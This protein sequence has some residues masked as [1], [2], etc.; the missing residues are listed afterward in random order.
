ML[1]N[2]L[3]KGKNIKAFKAVEDSPP[4]IEVNSKTHASKFFLVMKLIAFL[5]TIGILQVSAH[6]YSQKVSYSG[7]N[8]PI[9][10]VLKAIEKQ[11]G[12]YLFYKY[13][14]IKDAK[15]ID[16]L[17]LKNADLKHA[18]SEI[19][20]D[21]PFEYFLKENTI[22]VNKRGTVKANES[23]FRQILIDVKGV[24]VDEK[25][26]PLPGASVKTKTGN[27]GTV[28]DNQ[29]RFSMKNLTEGTVL[30][31]SYTGFETKEIEVK[32]N[33]DLHITL[34][35]AQSDL[36]E[37]VVVGYG[38]QKKELVT[39]AIGSLKIKD[40][41]VRQVASVTRL[42]EG[43]IAGV[44]LS[45]GSGNLASAERV[46][47][48]GYSSITAGNNPLYVVDGVPINTSNLSLTDFGENYSPLAVLN[49]ADVE[50]IEVLKDAASGAIYGSR[51]SN[52]V[53]L[54]TTK[55][56]KEGKSQI[57]FDLST[58]FSEFA[59]KN[60]LKLASSD[61]YLLQ[62]NEGAENYNK[63]YGLKIGDSGY[64]TPI[65]NPFYDMPDTDWLGL[66]LQKGYFKNA[67]ASFLGGSAKTNYFVGIGLTDQEGVVKNN[68][69]KKV[70]LNTKI[71]HKFTDWLE[72][73]ADNKGNFI[74]NNQV[75]GATLGSTIIARAI[76]Q[77]PFDRPYKPNGEYYVGGTDE[78]VR[79]N[80]IQILN[81]QDVYV[82]NYRYLGTFYGKLKFSKNISFRSSFSTDMGYTYDYTYYNEKHPYGTGVGRLVDYTRF[83]SNNLFENVLDYNG[84]F[85]KFSLNGVLGHSFQQQSYRTIAVDGRGF[86]S[87][88][89]NV[90]SVASEIF[91]ANGSVSEFAMESYFGRATLAYDD[92]YIFTGTVRTDGSSK[93][94]KD[95]RWG[96]F[97]SLSVGWNVS[98]EQFMQSLNVDLKLRTSWG[99]TGNQEGIGN[100]SHLPLISGGKNYGNVS[101]ISVSSFGNQNL[102]WEKADQYDFGFDLSLFNRKIDITFDTYYKKTTDLLYSMPVHAT[103][104]MTALLSNIGSMENRGVELGISYNQKI[105]NLSWSSSFN[106]AHNKNKILSLVDGDAPISIG[107]NRALQ[108]GRD[109]GSY[110]LFQAQGIYQYDGEV[111]KEQFD[112]G[113]RAGDIRWA[114]VDGNG[115]I[116]DNDRVV[117]G[118]S[119]PKFTGG[120]N[121]TFKFKNFQLDILTTYMYGQNV[122]A[123]WKP[124]GLGRIGHTFAQLEEYIDNRWTGPGSTNVYPRSILSLSHNNRNSTRFLEDG[125]FIRLRAV[126]LGYSIPAFNINGFQIKNVRVYGQV[127]NLFLW[128]RYSGWDPEVNT[129]LDPRYSGIDLLNNP[130]PRTFSIGTNIN[131]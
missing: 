69:L 101:G 28:T 106:I 97:P 126:T 105:G 17:N 4:A 52:G 114:D 57:R 95:N 10:K 21:Q 8:V 2:A 85:N 91:S 104:G 59:N 50:S 39:S 49:H 53:I 44:N 24:V 60:K 96:V 100:Y 11:T 92:K 12:Y 64:R 32:A 123:A 47:I 81:E 68:S 93:F 15:T 58:G 111:P 40:E 13:N 43:R 41:D 67:N 48:R 74:R 1:C 102:T 86:P 109:I 119:T 87:P 61:L 127:D 122:Y 36:N 25:A 7:K 16:N 18:L 115:I 77:R 118:S 71:N 37:I 99:K 51:A 89:F 63:Q 98:K 35:A 131:F 120:W 94:N 45:V 55:S 30:L 124:T 29:G 117:T 128:T 83:I 107:D 129:N 130:Q 82:D 5:I 56:G 65:M 75:P 121:N 110:Y 3:N 70:N 26:E 33:Q 79:H 66:I 42:L 31:I 22:I 62:Y 73:G 46:S 76:E 72:I 19:F 88:S 103:T 9:E 20:R 78:L 113:V 125:S 112:L 38:S 80:P 116:N 84:K 108:V 54:I 6:S 14:E 34:K 27:I 90:I 23:S